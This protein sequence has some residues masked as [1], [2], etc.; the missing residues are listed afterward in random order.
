MRAIERSQLPEDEL[1]KV[2][3]KDREDKKKS[4]K[5]NRSLELPISKE[6][7]KM[8]VSV[9]GSLSL[10]KPVPKTHGRMATI[11]Q[12]FEY[13]LKKELSDELYN[14]KSKKSKSII[15]LHKTVEYLKYQKELNNE[16]IAKFMSDNEERTPSAVVMGNKKRIWNFSHIELLLDKEKVIK[17]AR[18]I[19]QELPTA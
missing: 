7:M 1:E 10:P 16:E 19:E 14:F 18:K 11:A 12:V 2:K 9:S 13:L 5:A 4:R 17:K 15:R 6:M 3:K 8:I